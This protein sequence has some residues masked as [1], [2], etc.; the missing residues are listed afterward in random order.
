[1]RKIV[2]FIISFIF[3]NNV[4]ALDLNSKYAYVYNVKEDKVMYEKDS[5]KEIKVA[6]LTK[7]MTAIIAIENI[8]NINK[9]VIISARDYRDYPEYAVAKFNIGEKVT[10]KDL[11]FGALLPSGSEAVNALVRVTTDS[12]EEFIKLMNEKAL[13]LNLKNTHFSNPI[14]KD[15]NNYSTMSDIARILEYALSNKIFKEILVYR[16]FVAAVHDT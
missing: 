2:I 16:S 5:N 10:V 6:S 11:L 4:Y 14:G 7:I 8:D 15:D 13:E 12:E 9:E 3:I 1:M